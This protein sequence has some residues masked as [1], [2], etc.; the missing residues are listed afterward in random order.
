MKKSLELLI[1]G[2][3]NIN[4]LKLLLINNN[5]IKIDIEETYLEKL[6]K[7]KYTL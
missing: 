5:E 1:T 3:W 4:W 7:T 6:K 2:D